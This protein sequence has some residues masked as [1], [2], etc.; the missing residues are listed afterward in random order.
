MNSE[1]NIK[2]YKFIA[3]L[4]EPKINLSELNFFYENNLKFWEKFVKICSSHLILPTVYIKLKNIKDSSIIPPND[5]LIYLDDIYKINFERNQL[6]INQLLFISDLFEKNK[7]NY[8]FL[9][10]SAFLLQNYFDDLKIRM[11]GDIDILVH[12]KNLQKAEQILKNEGFKNPDG[13]QNDFTGE[14]IGK[15]NRHLKRLISSEYITAIELHS[16]LLKENFYRLLSANEV[17]KSKVKIDKNIYIPSKEHLFKHAILNWQINDKGYWLNFLS[18]K[19]VYDVICLENFTE[20]QIN[21]QEKEIKHFISLM[22]YF[23]PR[24]KNFNHFRKFKYMLQLKYNFFN[25]IVY[26]STHIYLFTILLFDRLILFFK[27]STY[28]NRVLK[29]PSKMISKIVSA[30]KNL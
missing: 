11:V 9:K 24:Y 13:I 25:K 23:Y 14:I 30:S 4:L 6:V 12:S 1:K 27:S 17:L 21:L 20:K 8:V 19:A 28:R 16:E 22:S 5:L 18:F 29:S 10:G 3:A 2:I 7:I 26:T 15:K